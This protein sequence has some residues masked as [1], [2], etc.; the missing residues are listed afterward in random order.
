MSSD[1]ETLT[2]TGQIILS[3]QMIS[4]VIRS[5]AVELI[6]EDLTKYVSSYR[7]ASN[8]GLC[9][10]HPGFICTYSCFSFYNALDTSSKG[11]TSSYT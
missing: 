9:H 5:Q 3:Q 1:I 6:Y 8:F 11:V 10:G 4:N 2:V 7:K